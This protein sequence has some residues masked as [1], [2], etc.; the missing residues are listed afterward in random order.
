M[1]LPRL[2]DDENAWFLKEVYPYEA[3]LRSWLK[4]KYPSLHNIDEIVQESYVRVL[5]INRRFKL[6]FPKAYLFATARNICID[7][8]RREKIVRFK[9]LTG[10]GIEEF[11]NHVRDGGDELI[12]KEEFQMLTDAIKTLPKKCRR[13]VTL[14]KVYGMSAKQI[15]SELKLSHRTVENQLM[16]G[17]KKCREYYMKLDGTLAKK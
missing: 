14:R 9:P 13:V 15:A 11:S 4:L 16:I 10:I 2:L 12:E 5:K 1:N 6:I 3:L 8:L 17:M 7:T